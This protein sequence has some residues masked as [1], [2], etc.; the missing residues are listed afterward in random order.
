MLNDKMIAITGASSGIGE[1]AARLIAREGAVPILMARSRDK[2]DRIAASIGAPCGVYALDVTSTEQVNETFHRALDR[3]GRID[4]LVNNAGFGLFERFADAPLEHF[5]QMMDVNY[6]GLVRCTKAVLPH[7]LQAGQG[8][9]VNIAS[10]AGKIG[11]A[12]STGY[13]ATKHA[14]LGFT[15][16]L[17]QELAGT[18]VRLSA[19]NPGPVDTAFFERADPSGTYVAGIKRLM[20][21]P[22]Q[23]AA[24]IVKVLRSGKA[25]QD[26]PAIMGLLTRLYQ[27][28]PRA[29]DKVAGRFM[30]RK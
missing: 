25:E 8:H 10:L 24:H 6:F 1:S 18:G 4:A 2:L 5:E 12:K 9:I 21:K 29:S 30:N 27:L 19:I 14:V 7:M 17:R 20:L 11:T 26:L 16:S 23:V 22:E 3:Y 13:A 28:F 15:N